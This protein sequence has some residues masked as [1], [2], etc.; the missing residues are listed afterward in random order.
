MSRMRNSYEERLFSGW[1]MG[2]QGGETADTLHNRGSALAK[3]LS[4]VMVINKQC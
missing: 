2:V 1:G 4:N 3:E